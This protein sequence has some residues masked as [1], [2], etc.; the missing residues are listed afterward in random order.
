MNSFSCSLMFPTETSCWRKISTGPRSLTPV[1]EELGP[2]TEALELPGD[3][4]QLWQ[5]I[6]YHK[7][8]NAKETKRCKTVLFPNIEIRGMKGRGTFNLG[9][10]QSLSLQ[11]MQVRLQQG[12]SG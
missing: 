11:L 10:K 9:D 1:R 7:E 3:N 4:C 12:E 2:K 6:A 5:I 8:G